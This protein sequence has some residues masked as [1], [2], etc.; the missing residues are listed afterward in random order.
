MGFLTAFF[1]LSE[2]EQFLLQSGM[3]LIP[4]RFLVFAE[5]PTKPALDQFHSSS[6]KDYI[7]LL[8]VISHFP[9]VSFIPILI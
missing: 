2:A 1:V 3:L 9:S 4:L 8:A 7:C 6:F 5:S